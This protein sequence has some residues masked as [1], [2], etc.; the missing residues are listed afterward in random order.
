MSVK[1]N[2]SSMVAI[3]SD[4]SFLVAA[5]LPSLC[6]GPGFALCGV[7]C[8]TSDAEIAATMQEVQ[9][10][11]LDHRLYKTDTS[12]SWRHLQVSEAARQ[13]LL[14]AVVSSHRR[15]RPS[16]W[17]LPPAIS[18]CSIQLRLLSSISH[19]SAGRAAVI[20]PPCWTGLDGS[21]SSHHISPL[22]KK[23]TGCGDAVRWPATTTYF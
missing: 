2:V 20:H 23:G 1:G 15:S 17:Q 13:E 18:S 5:T 3:Q 21:S 12:F 19:I 10:G 8:L 6:H 4:F 7:V 16:L 22:I 14:T 9:K 11:S